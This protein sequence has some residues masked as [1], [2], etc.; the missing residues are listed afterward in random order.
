MTLIKFWLAWLGIKVL[1]TLGWMIVF[2]TEC[3]LHYDLRDEARPLVALNKG[4]C[5]L[6]DGLLAWGMPWAL[7]DR[8]TPV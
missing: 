8:R 7:D 2:L 5:V 3:F 6:V 4:V 1:L